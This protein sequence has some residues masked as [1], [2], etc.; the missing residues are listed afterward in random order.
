MIL[1][2]VTAVEGTIVVYIGICNAEEH[3]GILFPYPS[4]F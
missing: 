2:P 1:I 4:F 3:S